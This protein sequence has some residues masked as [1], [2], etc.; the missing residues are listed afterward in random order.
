MAFLRDRM[1]ADGLNGKLELV[2]VNEEDWANNW[3]QY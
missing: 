2:G 1:A 3:K